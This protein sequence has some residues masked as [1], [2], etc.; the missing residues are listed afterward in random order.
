M[1]SFINQQRAKQ[2]SFGGSTSGK[3]YRPRSIK[4]MIA[5]LKKPFVWPDPPQDL[6]P[7]DHKLF[8]AVEEGQDK[9]TKEA[10]QA[11]KYGPR[12][13]RSRGEAGP[14][15]AELAMAAGAL[16]YGVSKWKPQSETARMIQA[17]QNAMTA[18]PEEDVEEDEAETSEGEMVIERNMDIQKE[19]QKKP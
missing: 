8:M 16:A 11:S 14:T 13:V 15:R 9:R 12:R 3:W 4:M 1:R 19:D 10:M 18:Q 2:R 5:D 7:W 17:A 6:E